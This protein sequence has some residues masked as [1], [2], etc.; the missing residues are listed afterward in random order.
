M[1]NI[2]E[3]Y[4]NEYIRNIIPKNKDFL[5][6]MEEYALENHIPIILP[7]VAQLIKVLIMT[8]KP[9]S[10]LEIGTA[11]AYS[12]LVMCDTLEGNCKITSIERREDMI[13]LAEHFISKTPYKNNINIIHGDA[14]DVLDN[15]D[16]KFDLIFMDAAKGQYME[17]FNKSINLLNQGGMIIAD[18]VLFRGMV[19]S[20]KLVERRKITI[21][22][23][24]R[25]F[26]KYIN[27]VEGFVSAVI[28]IGDGVALIYREV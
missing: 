13:S 26:L 14:I 1:A 10:I 5:L 19:A 9:K 12:A 7:E 2:N 22:K 16:D 11:I 20:D 8:N 27:E 3:E 15:I 18:N 6:D 21:V 17:F 28:P 4:I 25:K 23:R 24:L